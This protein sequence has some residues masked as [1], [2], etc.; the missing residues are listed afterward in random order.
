MG[1][2]PG[3]QQLLDGAI[4]PLNTLTTRKSQ[5]E[6]IQKVTVGAPILMG[7]PPLLCRGR[8][9]VFY[10]LSEEEAADA[11]LYLTRYPPSEKARSEPAI[12]LL[13]QEQGGGPRQRRQRLAKCIVAGGKH[14]GRAGAARR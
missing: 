8:M 2:D 12:A 3:P 7:T 1:P 4:P 6:F 9:P 14:A 11:Y 5:P 10:Y 13:Q